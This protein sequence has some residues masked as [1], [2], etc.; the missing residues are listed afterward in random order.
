MVSAQLCALQRNDWPETDAGVC[1]AFAFSKPQNAEDLLPGQV[2]AMFRHCRVKTYAFEGSSI[3]IDA[4]QSANHY[5]NV[6][7]EGAVQV[8]Q[9]LRISTICRTTQNDACVYFWPE[10][11]LAWNVT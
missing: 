2:S 8:Q 7:M 6:L 5:R 1:A 11:M 10:F 9:G 3:R 4:F